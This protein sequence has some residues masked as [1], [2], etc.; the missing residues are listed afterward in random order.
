MV[1]RRPVVVHSCP[2]VR[3]A[4]S[5]AIVRRYETLVRS[6]VNPDTN[7]VG[8]A[9]CASNQIRF[10]IAV[11][12]CCDDHVYPS[13]ILPQFLLLLSLCWVTGILKD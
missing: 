1:V 9:F 6:R 3:L 4:A 10:A 5:S 2:G 13:P 12:I 8:A 11:Y 7:F